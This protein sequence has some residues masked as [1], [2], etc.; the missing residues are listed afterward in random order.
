MVKDLLKKTQVCTPNSLF[1]AAIKILSVSLDCPN[2]P[3]HGFCDE[4]NALVPPPMQTASLSEVSL[5]FSM[6]CASAL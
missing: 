1:L 6:I 5:C 4:V 2:L 3:F